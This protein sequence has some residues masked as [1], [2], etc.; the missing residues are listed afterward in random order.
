M[1]TG[2]TGGRRWPIRGAGPRG[3]TTPAPRRK[4]TCSKK[5]GDLR[6]RN[7]SVYYQR[8]KRQSRPPGRGCRLFHDH[9][10]D[11][12]PAGIAHAIVPLGAGLGA[13]DIDPDEAGGAVAGGGDGNEF[14]FVATVFRK[15]DGGDFVIGGAVQGHAVA[16]LHGHQDPGAELAEEVRGDAVDGG[17]GAQVDDEGAVGPFPADPVLHESR[18]AV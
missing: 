13:G 1:E 18:A 5:V 11:E 8:S 6:Q 3:K 14:D 15:V 17:R 2:A 9:L 10:V 7:K 4:V 16:D 12:E